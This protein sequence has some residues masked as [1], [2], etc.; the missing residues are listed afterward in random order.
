MN[1]TLSTQLTNS[2][3]LKKL[4]SGGIKNVVRLIKLDEGSYRAQY[5]LD[6]LT[7]DE[8]YSPNIYSI[9]ISDLSYSMSSEKDLYSHSLTGKIY[10]IDSDIESALFST[11]NDKYFVIFSPKSE[12]SYRGFGFEFGAIL[13]YKHNINNDESSWEVELKETSNFPLFSLNNDMFDDYRVFDINYV[14]I[15]SECEISGGENTGYSINKLYAGVDTFNRP[16]DSNGRLISITSNKQCAK[17][18]EDETPPADYDIV[19]EYTINDTIDGINVKNYDVSTCS[20]SGSIIVSPST[21]NIDTTVNLE[22][23][24]SITSDNYWSILDKDSIVT[25]KIS[26]TEGVAGDQEIKV[27]NG[28]GGSETI[29][30]KN[31]YTGE[32][33]NLTVNSY[34]IRTDKTEYTIPAGTNIY[35]IPVEARGGSGNFEAT[36]TLSSDDVE[37]E[38]VDNIIYLIKKRSF[39]ENTDMSLT[40]THTDWTDESKIL[41]ITFQAATDTDPDYVLVAE[42]CEIE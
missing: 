27:E 17:I 19:G 14:P 41:N 18:L 33:A 28:L 4:F 1:C 25:F 32:L 36:K 15:I 29:R 40:I 23:E 2:C 20:I 9:N 13:E 6:S 5:G 35:T 22:K 37:L 42:Y 30:F 3:G 24:I 26:E 39:T 21:V 38:V 16:L 10:N 8:I 34:L 11:R 12:S 31:V 7:I